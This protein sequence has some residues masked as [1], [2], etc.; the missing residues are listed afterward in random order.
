MFEAKSN[1]IKEQIRTV[2]VTNEKIMHLLE[3]VDRK[4]FVP[5][6]CEDLA[7]AETALPLPH[8]EE[9]LSPSVQARILEALELKQN[10]TVLEIGTGTGFLTAM[11]ASLS[12]KVIS[13]EF[14][15]DISEIAKKN[16]NNQGILNVELMVGNGAAGVK[17]PE[18]VDVIVITG[19][20]PFLPEGFK[21][22]LK[23]K[24][25]ILAILGNAV[26]QEVMLFNRKNKQFT[27]ESL[28]ETTTKVLRRAPE[29]ERFTF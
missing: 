29:V 11:L 8:D 25:R 24:G 14:H 15:K 19:A 26:V 10:E 13:V 1:M 9:M 28:F 2:G 17:L 3:R 23:P 7:Y 27:T 12:H 21:A 6:N 5:K 16:L 4:Y 18:P 22:F 20:L